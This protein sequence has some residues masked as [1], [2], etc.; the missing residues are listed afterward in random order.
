MRW[1]PKNAFLNSH[2]NLLRF[3]R[4]LKKHVVN[5]QVV[6]FTCNLV[7]IKLSDFLDLH[8]SDSALNLDV[9]WIRLLKRD[10]KAI[11]SFAISEM[12]VADSESQSIK[13]NRTLY[14]DGTK[15]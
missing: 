11:F 4:S 2:E 9:N 7:C 13:I 15:I 12:K 6:R 1:I 3:S 8:I 10:P 5:V 14:V